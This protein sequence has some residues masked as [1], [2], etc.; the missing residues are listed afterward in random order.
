LA[1]ISS[2]HQKMIGRRQHHCSVCAGLSA[3]TERVW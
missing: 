1:A 2:F 3:Q